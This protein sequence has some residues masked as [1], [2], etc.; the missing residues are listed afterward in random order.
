MVRLCTE[1]YE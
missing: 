1:D